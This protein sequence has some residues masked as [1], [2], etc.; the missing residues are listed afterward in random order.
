MLPVKAEFTIMADK[1]S[2]ISQLQF[3][4]D[5][6][7]N[8]ATSPV[9]GANVRLQLVAVDAEPVAKAAHVRVAM[10]ELNLRANQFSHFILQLGLILRNLSIADI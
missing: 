5:R 10:L 7:V 8:K 6:S 3:S 2:K 9:D 1:P 4:T